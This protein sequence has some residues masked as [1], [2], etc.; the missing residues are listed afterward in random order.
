MEEWKSG[1]ERARQ[2]LGHAILQLHSGQMLLRDSGKEMQ[3]VLGHRAIAQWRSKG[4]R[5]RVGQQQCLY[6][7]RTMM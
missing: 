5:I 2:L 7:L 3:L 1:T 6:L 4:G